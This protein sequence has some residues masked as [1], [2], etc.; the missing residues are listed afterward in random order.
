[1]PL[2]QAVVTGLVVERC[3]DGLNVI[4]WVQQLEKAGDA[5]CKTT[6]DMVASHPLFA[7]TVQRDRH[8]VS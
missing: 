3:V 7:G 5:V 4:P 2:A 8:Q 1:M 6:C